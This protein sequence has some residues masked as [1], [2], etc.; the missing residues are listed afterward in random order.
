VN[1]ST[2]LQKAKDI[3]RKREQSGDNDIKMEEK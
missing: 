1:I 3:A 2:A